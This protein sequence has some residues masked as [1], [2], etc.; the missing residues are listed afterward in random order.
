MSVS[1]EIYSRSKVIH[2]ENEL[3]N[4]IMSKVAQNLPKNKPGQTL[5][6]YGI[7]QHN[8]YPNVFELTVN[9]PKYV[10]FS[11]KRYLENSF[12]KHFDL[13][14]VSLKLSFRKK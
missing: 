4:F 13:L 6:I 12:R 8:I 2:Q 10:H 11:Y 3:N 7:T 5:H 9:N 14:G 1:N